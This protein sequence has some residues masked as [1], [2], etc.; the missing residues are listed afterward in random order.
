[1]VIGGIVR[2]SDGA[3]RRTGPS[4]VRSAEVFSTA[5]VITDIYLARTTRRR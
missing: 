5:R 4:K 2:A 1:M 3:F